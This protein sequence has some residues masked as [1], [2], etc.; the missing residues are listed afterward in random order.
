MRDTIIKILHEQAR[1]NKDIILITG[2]LGF[3]VLDN[4]SKELPN[5]YINAGVAEQNMTAIAAGLALEGKKVFTYSIGNFNTLR[6]LEQIRNDICYHD[7]DVTIISVGGGF[8]YGQLGASHFA[9]EDIA[10]MSALPNM[11]VIAPS[12]KK[13]AAALMNQIINDKSPCYLRIDKSSADEFIKDNCNFS[14]GKINPTSLPSDVL[15]FGYG[16]ILREAYKAKDALSKENITVEIIDVHSIK[17]LD[18]DGILKLLPNRPVVI[19]LE[20]HNRAGGLSYII[21]NLCISN[22]I[23]PRKF[24]SFCLDD[25]FPKIVGD[26]DFL[27]DH[28]NLTSRHLIKTIKSIEI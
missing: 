4:Y 19:T 27:L 12:S 22:S 10:I 26:Q 20:E 17:P 5:Q 23:M 28:F 3:G 15:I 18:T 11:K 7:L 8:S 24:Y 13:S 6:C 9:T 21:S 1:I 16:G 25:L 14:I 2:D